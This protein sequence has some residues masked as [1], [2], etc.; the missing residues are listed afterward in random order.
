MWFFGR[1]K[2]IVKL[3][4]NMFEHIYF[5]AFMVIHTLAITHFAMADRCVRGEGDS[6]LIK[7]VIKEASAQ[8]KLA[9][10]KGK[11]LVSRCAG[12]SMLPFKEKKA[13]A[14]FSQTF[15]DYLLNSFALHHQLVQLQFPLSE[16]KAFEMSVKMACQC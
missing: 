13:V 10:C 14:E 15:N 6:T 9:Y 2:Q 16:K 4:A 12:V 1:G 8:L 3:Q 11:Y 7:D 5:E